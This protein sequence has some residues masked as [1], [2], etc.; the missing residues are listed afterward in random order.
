MF[1]GSWTSAAAL[2]GVVLSVGSVPGAEAV[3]TRPDPDK[4]RSTAEDR[5]SVSIT[6][7][8][9]NFGLVREVRSL[10]LARGIVDLEF[11]DVASGIQPETVLLRAMN[12]AGDLSVLEQLIDLPA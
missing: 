3:A 1:G 6:V 10:D 2:L 11:G 8:N 4:F 5:E 9:Q 12:R 7:Y